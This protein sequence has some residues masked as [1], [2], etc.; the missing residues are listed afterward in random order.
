MQSSQFQKTLLNLAKGK[1]ELMS[2]LVV[3]K[4]T[5]KKALN[6]MGKRFKGPVRH[7]QMEEDSSKEDENHN[8]DARSTCVGVAN[9]QLL[10]M[11]ITLMRNIHR[12]KTKIDR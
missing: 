5:K 1:Q 11:E 7:V 6:N 3:K 2:L 8:E 12:L 4:K 10:R 9:N